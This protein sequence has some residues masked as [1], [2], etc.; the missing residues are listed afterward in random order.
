[1]LL[2]LLVNACSEGE[3]ILTDPQIELGTY[4]IITSNA[5]ADSPALESSAS[6]FENRILIFKLLRVVA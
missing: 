3:E 2:V 4:L 1:M 5:Y 6:P